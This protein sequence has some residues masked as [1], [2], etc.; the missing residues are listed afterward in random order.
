MHSERA[1]VLQEADDD[2]AGAVLGRRF[3]V[4]DKSEVEP[5]E[6]GDARAPA[7]DVRRQRHLRA[8][9]ARHV[10][11]EAHQVLVRTN[12]VSVRRTPGPDE[13]EARVRRQRGQSHS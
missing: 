8:R 13:R 1:S 10:V 9:A 12:V 11:P 2:V 7:A 4:I 6:P 5:H 3:R